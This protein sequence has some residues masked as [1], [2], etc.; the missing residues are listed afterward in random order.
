MTVTGAGTALMKNGNIPE[1]E[2][3]NN[4][5]QN[6]KAPNFRS[7]DV[8]FTATKPLNLTFEVTHSKGTTAYWIELQGMRN[9]TPDDWTGL[10][11]ELGFLDPKTEKFT[12]LAAASDPEPSPGLRFL[13]PGKA[14]TNGPNS[15]P[16]KN[17]KKRGKRADSIRRRVHHIRQRVRPEEGKKTARW[18]NLAHLPH[19]CSSRSEPEQTS[20]G[21]SRP[22]CQKPL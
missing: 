16:F 22:R 10:K 1:Q 12:G 9:N 13:V 21:S 11:L 8:E 4:R 20:P 19:S 17:A 15:K 2:K 18:G 3:V 6:G 5:T 7:I 14:Y